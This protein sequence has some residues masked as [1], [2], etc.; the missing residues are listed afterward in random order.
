MNIKQI[1]GLT[2]RAIENFNMFNEGDII[3]VGLSGGKDSMALLYVLNEISHYHP[4]NIKV[5]AFSVNVGFENMDFNG[6]KE[7][8]E[9]LNVP[10]TLINTHIA[11]IAFS[12]ENKNSPCSVCAKL[13]KGALYDELNKRNIN[14]IAYAHHKDDLTNTLLMSLIFE[15]R[16][17]TFIPVTHLEDSNITVL[18][19]FIYVN[20]S[21]IKGFVKKYSI[22]ILKNTCPKDGF[23]TRKYVNEL[24]NNINKDYHGVRNRILTAIE[25]SEIEGWNKTK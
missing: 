3:A 23:T 4:C 22:P 2:R 10:F 25:N 11:D 1:S 16:I 14:K 12:S 5:E 18:R 20:E 6:V 13:R 21:D 9:S 24:I 7:Y 19:P 17:N 15:G 8:C